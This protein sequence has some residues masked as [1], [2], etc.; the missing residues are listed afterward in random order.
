MNPSTVAD[1]EMSAKAAGLRYV[2]ADDPGIRRRPCG[3][4]F[5]YLCTDGE[6]L[7]DPGERERI[8][9][10]A[11]PP[12]WTDVWICPHPDGHVLATGRD[13]RGR[14]QYR[15][16]PSWEEIRARARFRRVLAFGKSLPTLRQRIGQLL[17]EDDR[18]PQAVISAAARLL[19][20]LALRVGH[21][22]YVEKNG[23]F[24]LTT[25][26]GRHLRISGTGIEVEFSGKGGAR[27]SAST[28]DPRLA[29]ILSG[30]SSDPDDRVFRMEMEGGLRDLEADDLN[31]WL[32]DALDLPCSAKDFRS[33]RAS[34]SVVS[35]LVNTDRPA[36]GAR[37][38]RYLEVVDDAAEA[39]A[40]TR[41]VLRSSYL[42]PGLEELYL[43][44]PF[45][46][47]IE[48]ARSRASADRTPARTADERIAIPVLEWLVESEARER[49]A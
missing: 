19:D 1:P 30:L 48:R 7:R 11:I 18:R 31:G 9:A 45:P 39:L 13:D 43:D 25:L 26:L 22:E 34:V 6:T 16:H 29:R 28:R 10:L 14:K 40:N 5:T 44:G 32:R 15:Y 8:E 4:G 35:D 38:G 49:A 2:G 24:G 36:G 17:A 20:R 3:R 21:E 37:I 23:T 47:V 41:G 12:A 33:W 27:V 42:P 46:R